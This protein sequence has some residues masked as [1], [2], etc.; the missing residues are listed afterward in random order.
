LLLINPFGGAGAAARNWVLAQEILEKSYID[1][2]VV[3]T[4]RAGHA[5]DIV[6]KKIVPKQYDCI[7]TVSGDGLVFEV[8]NGIMTRPDYDNF[9]DNITFG[10]IPGGTSNG[11]VKSI[12]Y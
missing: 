3:E 11:L 9:K 10:P 5:F 2:K 8:V 12:L 7:S 4:E 6:N 1:L